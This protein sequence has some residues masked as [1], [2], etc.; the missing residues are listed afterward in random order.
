MDGARC[1]RSSRPVDCRCV[2]GLTER[3]TVNGLRYLEGVTTLAL[4]ADKCTGCR[5][6]VEVCPHAVFEMGADKRASIRDL[7]A[8]ME[9]GACATNCA[10]GAISLKPG[11]GCAQAIINSWVFGGEPSCDCK[12]GSAADAGNSCC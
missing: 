10:W 6:C 4:D 12:G 1:T 9:C 8:C 3:T 7:D 5:M 2:A 11:V